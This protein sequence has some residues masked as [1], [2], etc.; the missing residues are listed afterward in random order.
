MKQAKADITFWMKSKYDCSTTVSTSYYPSA[1][2]QKGQG[3]HNTVLKSHILLQIE[4]QL[5]DTSVD[6]I[7][8]TVR[9]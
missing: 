8:L 2:K 7:V 6:I 9:S 4:I 5:G 1:F 3:R